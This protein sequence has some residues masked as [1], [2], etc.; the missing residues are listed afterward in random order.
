[1]SKPSRLAQHRSQ[2]HAIQPKIVT[3]SRKPKPPVAPPVYRPQ[4]VPRVLQRKVATTGPRD[5]AKPAPVAPP[6]YR[7]QPTPKVLQTKTART[8]AAPAVVQA[9]KVAIN[10]RE[11]YRQDT[12]RESMTRSHHSSVIQ[13][14]LWFTGDAEPI[15]PRS[16]QSRQDVHNEITTYVRRA[17]DRVG[18]IT[19]ERAQALRDDRDLLARVTVIPR[20]EIEHCVGAIHGRLITWAGDEEQ[21]PQTTVSLAVKAAAES[22]GAVPLLRRI[23]QADGA[24]IERRRQAEEARRLDEERRR[25]EGERK[26]KEEEGKRVA[27]PIEPSDPDWL[28]EVI[29]RFA[30]RVG[31]VGRFADAVRK[32]V[33]D[34]KFAFVEGY[35]YQAATALELGD[36]LEGM[37]IPY[38]GRLTESR[39]VDLVT[40]DGRMIECKV[41]AKSPDPGEGI[42]KEFFLQA[43]EY[44]QAGTNINYRFKNGLPDWAR[45][46]LFCA[47]F[48]GNGPILVNGQAVAFGNVFGN[49]N[50]VPNV[51]NARTWYQ[52]AL[53]HGPPPLT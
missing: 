49:K 17:M 7:P 40:R 13:R 27:M 2:P 3:A 37:E 32:A 14:K 20:D 44:A 5:Q 18:F 10:P 1:M 24:D 9:K 30:G 31:G 47:R 46:L 42:M 45:Q 51:K 53:G 50:D 28:K 29:T 43:L 15:N 12:K 48:W 21:R 23:A 34:G 4:P 6:A 36:N 35:K 52:N 11:Q 8:P 33:K 26:R 22:L 38:Q 19:E 16:V 39:Y 25:V 41:F